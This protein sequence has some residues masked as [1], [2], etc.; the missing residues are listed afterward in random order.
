MLLAAELIHVMN[1]SPYIRGESIRLIGWHCRWVSACVCVFFIYNFV[2]DRTGKSVYAMLSK[3]LWVGE[4]R[5]E[6]SLTFSLLPSM[7]TTFITGVEPDSRKQI[8]IRCA[9][10][11]CTVWV[12][13]TDKPESHVWYKYLYGNKNWY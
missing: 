3:Y 11:L 12:S 5:H 8:M 10:F 4:R 2:N 1:C 7:Y 13:T 6:L 9:R